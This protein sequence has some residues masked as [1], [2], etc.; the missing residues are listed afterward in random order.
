MIKLNLGSGHVHLS[1]N[2]GWINIVGNAETG[3]DIVAFIPP[4]P[5]DDESVDQILASHFIEHVEDT[6]FLFNECWRVLKMVE[7]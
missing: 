3:C 2:E 1:N 5:M 7:Q 4:I 6:I